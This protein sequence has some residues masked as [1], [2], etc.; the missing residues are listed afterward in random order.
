MAIQLDL[1]SLENALQRLSEGLQA[2]SGDTTNSLYRDASI[3]RFEFCYE[4]SHKMLKRYLELASPNPVAIDELAFPDL[5]RSGNEQGLLRNGWDK[6]KDYR[7][8]RSITNHTYDESKAIEVM[9]IVPD[10]LLEGQSL[11]DELKKRGTPEA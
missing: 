4:L 2:Y 1:S 9:Q 3:Q 5:I 8:A 7:K 11:L 6:W 10:F